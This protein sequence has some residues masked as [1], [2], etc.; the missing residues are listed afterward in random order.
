MHEHGDAR[1][2]GN[3]LLEELK[4]LPIEIRRNVTQSRDVPFWV[5][6]VRDEPF[7]NRIAGRYNDWDRARGLLGSASREVSSCHNHLDVETDKLGRQMGQMVCPPLGPTVLDDD[8]LP[9]D[10]AKVAQTLLECLDTWIGGTG[11]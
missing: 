2:V 3:R 11:I 7:P 10:V 6:E 1:E 8:V 9:L 5:G 4:P